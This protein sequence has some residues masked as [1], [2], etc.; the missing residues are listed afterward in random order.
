MTGFASSA[1]QIV[2]SPSSGKLVAEFQHNIS[3]YG[4]MLVELGACVF[5]GFDFDPLTQTADLFSALGVEAIDY[6]ERSSPRTEVADRVYTATDYPA[7]HAIPF[8]NENSYQASWP[9]WLAFSCVQPAVKGGETVLSDVAAVAQQLG[10]DISGEFREYGW[11]LRRN[12]GGPIGLDWRDAFQTSSAEEVDD[13]CRANFISSS[14]HDGVLRTEA[15]RPAFA[16]HPD[17]GVNLWFNHAAFFHLS[18]LDA[19]TRQA[20]EDVMEEEEYPSQT[21]LGDGRAIST[22]MLSE[23]RGAYA[24][25]AMEHEWESGDVVIVDNMRLAHSRQPYEGGRKILVGLGGLVARN[26]EG[27]R[28]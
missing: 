3:E 16:T 14:W 21:F 15:I 19:L 28:T 23:I 1:G 7:R 25:A 5:R 17:T 4:A 9:R 26:D 8:H 20:I 18:S 12:Y 22:D 24:D 27:V 10:E 13:Y 11:A 6:S 2:T